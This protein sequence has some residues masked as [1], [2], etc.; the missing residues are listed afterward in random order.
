MFIDFSDGL[1]GCL[2]GGGGGAPSGAE[3]YLTIE[4][5]AQRLKLAPKTLR[6]KMAAGLLRE[7]EHYFRPPGLGPRFK[8]SA[9]AAWLEGRELCATQLRATR[10]PEPPARLDGI[11]MARGYVLGG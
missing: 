2:I 3:E 9:V 7:G 1:L 6:N 8:W 4:E 11:P 5:T 10:G